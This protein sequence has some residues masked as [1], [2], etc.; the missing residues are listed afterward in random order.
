MDVTEVLSLM[1]GLTA[2]TLYGDRS[3]L[4]WAEQTIPLRNRGAPLVRSE[5]PVEP[6]TKGPGGVR[7]PVTQGAQSLGSKI[8]TISRNGRHIQVRSIRRKDPE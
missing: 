7:R 1:L 4:C 3:A 5:S 2:D 8:R 6:L